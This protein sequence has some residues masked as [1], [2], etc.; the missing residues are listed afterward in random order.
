MQAENN[1]EILITGGNGYI[2]KNLFNTLKTKYRIT[3][4]TREDFDLG[5]SRAVTEWF[6]NKTFDV[7]IHTASVGGNRLLKED[8]NTIDQN[9]QMYYNLLSN[10]KQFNK[11]ITFGSGAELYSSST[12]YGL[13]KQ[14]IRNSILNKKN[15]YNLRIYAV[16]DENELDNRFIK[17]NINRYIN[18]EK[19]II[20]QDRNMDFIYMQDL[21]KI[22]DYYI[23]NDDLPK[24][25]DCVYEKT[26]SLIEISNM[27]NCLDRYKVQIEIQ[28][29]GIQNYNGNSNSLPIN[30]IGLK[31]GIKNVYEKLKHI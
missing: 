28:S 14:V 16:F 4:V 26:Y 18:K 27:I 9:L 13:S 19:I 30:Y 23:Q 31:Q 12:P 24:E 7:V 29:E 3:L 22:V 5:D 8:E 1:M 6:S 25:I 10:K 21:I 20:Y 2:S 11:F 15:Y 17:A